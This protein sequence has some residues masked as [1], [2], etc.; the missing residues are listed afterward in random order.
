MVGCNCAQVCGCYELLGV[1][2]LFNSNGLR[3]VGLLGCSLILSLYFWV[4]FLFI[5]G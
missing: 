2:L 1:K 4:V 3:D 5:A